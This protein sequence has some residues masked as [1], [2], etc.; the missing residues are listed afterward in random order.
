VNNCGNLGNNTYPEKEGFFGAR[1]DW[2]DKVK[3]YVV[4]LTC[5]GREF[6]ADCNNHYAGKAYGPGDPLVENFYCAKQEEFVAKN[7]LSPCVLA[8]D[9]GSIFVHPFVL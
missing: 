7:N 2:I 5:K 4:S 3:G 6:Y 1:D 9:I 8:Y